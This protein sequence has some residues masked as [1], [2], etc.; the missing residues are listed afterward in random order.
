MREFLRNLHLNTGFKR[1]ILMHPVTE[2]F[3]TACI[4]SRRLRLRRVPLASLVPNPNTQIVLQNLPMNRADS[5]F[6][7]IAAV[8]LLAVSRQPRRVLEIGTCRGRT[9]L[10]LAMNLPDAA[11]I[12]YD[13]DPKAGEYIHGHPLEHR[14]DLRLK[15]I[16]ADTEKLRAE[17]PFD[18]IY[19]DGDHMG[20][21][22]RRDSDLAFNLLAPAGMIVWHDYANWGW[23]LG[24][25]TVPETLAALAET[26]DIVA[27]ERTVLAAYENKA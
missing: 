26:R 18:F 10:S 17:P 11:L 24:L 19:V 21:N 12:T 8:C 23:A 16:H 20:Q 2:A 7:D 9:T 13:I 22:P 3:I 27:I 15:D 4:T 25:N 1:R 14:I 5:P 6:D